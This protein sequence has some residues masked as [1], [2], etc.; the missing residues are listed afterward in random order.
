MLCH[1]NQDELSDVIVKQDGM[2][3]DAGGMEQDNDSAIDIQLEEYAEVWWKKMLK[4]PKAQILY[5]NSHLTVIVYLLTLTFILNLLPI[6]VTAASQ[7]Q[8]FIKSFI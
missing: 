5:A 8:F 7:F 3:T 2:I 1:I 6:Y 4:L